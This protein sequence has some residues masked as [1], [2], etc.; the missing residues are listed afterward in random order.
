MRTSATHPSLLKFGASVVI[1]KGQPITN[2]PFTAPSNQTKEAVPIGAA[3]EQL[4]ETAKQ[5][6]I[7][8]TI[9]VR[10]PQIKSISYSI[11]TERGRGLRVKPEIEWDFQAPPNANV[12]Q[13][14]V[15]LP[16]KTPNNFAPALAKTRHYLQQSLNP[17][18]FNKIQ[19]PK[20][21]SKVEVEHK[22]E[23]RP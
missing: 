22:V 20:V 4:V 1:S 15:M 23:V 8:F 17:A 19:F 21:E 5:T 14:Q 3:L 7:N 6:N 9:S 2:V 16:R 18:T 10:N 11:I 12:G 13:I